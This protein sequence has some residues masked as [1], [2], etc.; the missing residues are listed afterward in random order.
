MK[1][2]KYYESLDKRT[3]EYKD[4]KNKQSEALGDTVEKVFKATGIDKLAK[5][6]LGDD[7]GCN[8]RKILLN[9]LYPY[10]KP[11]CLNEKEYDYLKGYFNKYPNNNQGTRNATVLTELYSI[12]RRVFNSNKRPSNCGSC[13]RNVL[14]Q[15]KNVYQTYKD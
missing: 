15:L 11:N 9:K 2:N 14:N 10:K 12:Y 13:V 7:C 6:I 1:D 8:E 4:W 3:K 5:F